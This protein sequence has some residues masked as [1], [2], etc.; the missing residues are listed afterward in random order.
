MTLTDGMTIP[1][2]PLAGEK[3]TYGEVLA[4]SGD[5]RCGIHLGDSTVDG[6]T[7]TFRAGLEKDGVVS[8]Y[9]KAVSF[10]LTHYGAV[11][12]LVD[13]NGV[14]M[15]EYYKITDA[16]GEAWDGD[17]VKLLTDATEVVAVPA[18]LEVTIDLN[19]KTLNGS[20]RAP[21]AYLTVKNGKIDNEN[22]SVSALE[23]NAGTL[24]L[25]DV[26][27]DSARHALRIDGAVVATINGGTYKSGIGE[28]TGSY[29]A[30]NVS[31]TA[32]V[33]VKGGTF[34]GPK[35]T[36][37]DSGAAVCVQ[38]GSKV[39]IDGGDF[40]GGKNNTLVASGSLTVTGGTYDQDPAKYLPAGYATYM[41]GAGF[42]VMKCIKLDIK[43]IDNMP[44]IGYA[45]SDVNGGTLILKATSTL[46]GTVTWTTITWA[47]DETLSDSDTVKD[48]VKPAEAE[49]YKFFTGGVAK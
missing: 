35:G 25:V 5:F 46:D 14:V 33:T 49:V 16:L 12:I 24:N 31:G 20:I 38:S 44:V 40:S 32:D 34:V 6:L 29:H 47:K 3:M 42:G 28:G 1:V 27:I 21:N 36:S 18:G 15:G 10:D 8:P 30:L 48:W 2:L 13:P 22:A 43:V 19:G 45:E 11:A 7:V 37:A 17:T 41:E 9:G 26:N 4:H 23:I 39:T